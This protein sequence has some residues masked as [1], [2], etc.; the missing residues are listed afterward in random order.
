MI[1]WKRAIFK[2]Q[3][4]KAA[5]EEFKIH[6]HIFYAQITEVGLSLSPTLLLFCWL[7]INKILTLWMSNETI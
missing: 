1:Y 5:T 2:K 6:Y 4:F 3:K 7:K